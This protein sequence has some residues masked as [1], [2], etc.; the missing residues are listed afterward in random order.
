M[1][2]TPLH[3]QDGALGRCPA[4]ERAEV[5]EGRSVRSADQ[6]E[7]PVTKA[8]VPGLDGAGVRVQQVRVSLRRAVE[9]V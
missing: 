3:I 1:T 8:R 5:C 9:V 4:A 6:E 7:H 2:R